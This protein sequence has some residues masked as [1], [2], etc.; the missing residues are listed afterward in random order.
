MTAPV[1][2]AELYYEILQ[3]KVERPK[4]KKKEQPKEEAPEE[5]ESAE[6]DEDVDYERFQ[7]QIFTVQKDPEAL[8]KQMAIKNI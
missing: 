4:R 1:Q 2:N 6:E 8:K 5:I 3:R 7:G